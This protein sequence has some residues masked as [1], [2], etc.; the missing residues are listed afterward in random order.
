MFELV[1]VLY[2]VNSQLKFVNFYWWGVIS[3]NGRIV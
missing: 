3:D 2:P 1:M